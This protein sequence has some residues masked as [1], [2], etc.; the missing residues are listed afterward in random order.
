L[1]PFWG[2]VTKFMSTNGGSIRVLVELSVELGKRLDASAV[3]RFNHWLLCGKARH[4]KD[5]RRLII[6][7]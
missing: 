2:I 5:R 6:D 4:P 3:L 7:Y 1:A